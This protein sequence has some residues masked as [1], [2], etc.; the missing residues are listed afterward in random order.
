MINFQEAVKAKTSLINQLEYDKKSLQREITKLQINNESIELRDLDIKEIKK[1]S[2]KQR[3]VQL[4]KS[5]IKKQEIRE[6][7]LQLPDKNIE[8]LLY[9]LKMTTRAPSSQK[10]RKFVNL[11]NRS[12]K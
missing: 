3:Q 5:S 8:G 10:S 1:R 9:A 11:K 2:E 6:K 12:V 7:V 4:Y